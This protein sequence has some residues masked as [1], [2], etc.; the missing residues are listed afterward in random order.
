[1]WIAIALSIGTAVKFILD[2]VADE[3]SASL[4]RLATGACI[5]WFAW[6]A[7]DPTLEGDEKLR[8]V[9]IF[10]TVTFGLI[11]IW[12]WVQDWDFKIFKYLVWV[13]PIVF[14]AIQAMKFPAY[15]ETTFS[16]AVVALS[17]IPPQY[18]VALA[19]AT[20]FLA[21]AKT[22]VEFTKSLRK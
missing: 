6:L 3:I 1:M 4:L 16:H 8:A 20:A 2:Y 22:C 21:F 7:V 9:I 12:E 19:A 18:L 14:F 10:A 5:S 13:P 15:V 17:S 11:A